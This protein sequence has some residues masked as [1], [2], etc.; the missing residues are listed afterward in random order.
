MSHPAS[1]P[2]QPALGQK[3]QERN[4]DSAKK[5]NRRSWL[6][7][8][9][10][11]ATSIMLLFFVLAGCTKEQ[12]DDVIGKVP[13]GG[14]GSTPD[15]WY[16]L[17]VRYGIGKR[18]TMGAV[19]REGYSLYWDYMAVDRKDLHAKFKLH[20][21]TDGW[22]YWETEDGYW[23]SLKATG[24]AYRSYES[25]RIEWKIVDGKLYN[26]YWKS[27]WQNYPLGAEYRWVSVSD[28]YY[29]GVGLGDDK[30][31]RDCELEPVQ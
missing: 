4:V 18:G 29:A 6:R 13:G 14:L 27:D 20:P 16:N 23:L 7:R 3:Q 1:N 2:H 30:V 25:N 28:A 31:L 15:Q 26:K 12:R 19:R 10:V 21:T 22:A 9:V 17:K 11:R 24:W 5:I 8:A